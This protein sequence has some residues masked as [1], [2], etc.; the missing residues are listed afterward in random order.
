MEAKVLAVKAQIDAINAEIQGMAAMN[1]YRELRNEEIAYNEKDFF[2][3]AEEL[4]AISDM[5]MNRML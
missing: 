3:K 5:I 4:R 2:D 1:Q